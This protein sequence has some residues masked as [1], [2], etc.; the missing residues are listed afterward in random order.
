MDVREVNY[1]V[2][3]LS[4]LKAVLCHSG[5]SAELPSSIWTPLFHVY[6]GFSN[7][8]HSSSF[9]PS[10]PIWKY[11]LAP[12]PLPINFFA[13]C[14]STSNQR[15]TLSLPILPLLPASRNTG[16]SVSPSIVLLPVILFLRA[17]RMSFPLVRSRSKPASTSEGPD[18]NQNTATVN[19]RA[20]NSLAREPGEIITPKYR[21]NPSVHLSP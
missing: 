19:L 17:P 11:Y 20:V 9:S 18:Q 2:R 4:L 5:S 7:V 16:Y 15:L 1:H 14:F 10:G 12:M 8:H 13:L 6:V 3:R 21:W